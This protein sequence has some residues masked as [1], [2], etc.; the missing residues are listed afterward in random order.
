MTAV[1][2]DENSFKTMVAAL[3]NFGTPFFNWEVMDTGLNLI[4]FILYYF[5]T[6]L[7]FAFY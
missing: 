4:I 2:N 3:S 1:K 6:L 7:K 5:N